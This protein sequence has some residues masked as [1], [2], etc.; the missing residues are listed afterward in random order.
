MRFLTAGDSVSNLMD[1][2]INL[3]YTWIIFNGS[4]IGNYIELFSSLNLRLKINVIL[5]LR[6]PLSLL[7]FDFYQMAPYIN[8]MLV[9]CIDCMNLFKIKTQSKFFEKTKFQLVYRVSQ[10]ECARL[11]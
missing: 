1:P 10:D 2:D 11:R 6:S 8:E 3:I 7:G 5:T 9:H 4:V